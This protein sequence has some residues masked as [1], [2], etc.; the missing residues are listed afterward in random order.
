MP[1]MTE[2]LLELLA[3]I[4]RKKE[5]L[6]DMSDQARPLGDCEDLLQDCVA[7]DATLCG[8]EAIILAALN[9]QQSERGPCLG[10]DNS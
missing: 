1:K 8:A 9:A 10:H 3:E 5:A 7:I 4:R 6:A 2:E